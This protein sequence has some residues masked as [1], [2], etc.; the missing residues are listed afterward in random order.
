MAVVGGGVLARM[1][2]AVKS[3][4]VSSSEEGRVWEVGKRFEL[5]GVE[6]EGEWWK[7]RLGMREDSRE[8]RGT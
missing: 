6:E 1:L 8:Q 5:D 7:R 4:W 3:V 2:R